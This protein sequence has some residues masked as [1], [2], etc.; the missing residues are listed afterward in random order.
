MFLGVDV[1]GIDPCTVREIRYGKGSVG[2]FGKK[3][4]GKGDEKARAGSSG[5]GMRV[6]TDQR[7]G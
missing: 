6:G 2:V 7:M 5:L 4:V 3:C 1:V